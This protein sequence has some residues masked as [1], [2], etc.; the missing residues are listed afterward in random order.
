MKRL[1]TSTLLLSSLVIAGAASAHSTVASNQATWADNGNTYTIV[2]VDAPITW[3]E[4]KS[5]A[6]AAGGYL[7]TLTSQAELDFVYDNLAY[8]HTYWTLNHGGNKIGPWL[9][10]TDEE[11]E[12]NW[13][14]VTGE[15]WDFTNWEVHQPDN[16]ANEEHYLHFFNAGVAAPDKTWNDVTVDYHGVIS[17]II[18][19]PGTV[20]AVPVPAAAFLFAPALLGFMGLRRKAKQAA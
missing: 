11:T 8:D 4:A 3:H 5:D 10:A 15:T 20:N 14:W 13:K 6:E 7:A 18:E 2:K 19:T 1:L 9:G 17:Y 16:F 12:D